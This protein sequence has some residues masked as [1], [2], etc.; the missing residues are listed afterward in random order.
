M[1]NPYSKELLCG[2]KKVDMS[3][4]GNDLWKMMQH[5]K[6]GDFMYESPITN[7]ISEIIDKQMVERE[8]FILATVSEKI[9]IDVNREEL[10]KALNYDRN[11]YEKGYTDAK[12]ECEPKW[13]SSEERF[14][15]KTGLYLISMGDLVT[16]GSFDGHIFRSRSMMLRFVPD[17]WMPLPK[18]YKESED[19][20]SD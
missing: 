18:P 3:K 15:Q 6:R 2:A 10:I 5:E 14:P 19:A 11:Q 8:N 13:I 12:A 7:Y 4:F 16:V 1:F 9:G 20:N 17:A